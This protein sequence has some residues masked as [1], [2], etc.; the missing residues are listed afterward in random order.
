MLVLSNH[1]MKTLLRFLLQQPEGGYF[2][3][4]KGEQA[5]KYKTPDPAVSGV[6]GPF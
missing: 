5:G 2:Q 4:V 6:L 3:S 1:P